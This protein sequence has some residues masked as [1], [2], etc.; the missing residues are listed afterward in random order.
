MIWST[1]VMD[2]QFA[3]SATSSWLWQVHAVKKMKLTVA[4]SNTTSTSIFGLKSQT[5]MSADTTTQAAL[6]T[7]DSSM[8]SAGLHSRVK[9]TVTPSSGTTPRT[10]L[11][12][13]LSSTCLQLNSQSVKA[14]V[15]YRSLLKKLWYLVDFQDASSRTAAFSTLETT[16]WG[17]LPCS[18]IWICSHSRCQQCESVTVPFSLQTGS[19]RRSLNTPVT[20][21]LSRLRTSNR[22][23]RNSDDHSNFQR[24][25][26]STLMNADKRQKK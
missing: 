3:A 6:T 17:R 9:S 16:P 14:Q 10:D 21:A 13:G 19:Q 4:A 22:L 18:Q 11:T 8:F 24:K 15:L 25:T 2:T 23:N 7:S 1:R 20:A 5:W 12:P 26:S